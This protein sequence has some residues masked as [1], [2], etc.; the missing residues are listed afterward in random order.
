[1]IN[2]SLE[3]SLWEKRYTEDLKRAEDSKGLKF[4]RVV[5]TTGNNLCLECCK[6]PE[7]GNYKNSATYRFLRDAPIHVTAEGCPIQMSNP[8]HWLVSQAYI[9]FLSSF[10]SCRNH[11]CDIMVRV[12]IA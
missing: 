10:A 5:G 9:R 3:I 2:A 8:P 11:Y 4:M 7:R 12:L 1:V 6:M